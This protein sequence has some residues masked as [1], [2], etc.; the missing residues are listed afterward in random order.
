M[1]LDTCP[2][3]NEQV[4]FSNDRC[5]NCKAARPAAV[6][7]PDS[8]SI[9]G[10]THRAWSASLD[11]VISFA[12]LSVFFLWLVVWLWTIKKH[13][14]STDT[15]DFTNPSP[16]GIMACISIVIYGLMYQ[17]RKDAREAGRK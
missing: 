9:V 16:L 17:A 7:T 10:T 15:L 4:E 6:S 14:F 2:N 5:P 12:L 8:T 3:C 13:G 11:R 1:C